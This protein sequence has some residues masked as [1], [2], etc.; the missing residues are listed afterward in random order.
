VPVQASDGAATVV[1]RPEQLVAT[2]VSDSS[3]GQ[4]RDGM[5]TVVGVEFLGH[6]VLL[7]ID[8]PGETDLIVVRQHSLSPPPID[9]K[10]RVQVVGSGVV[11]S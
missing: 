1:L 4:D 10:V 9:A 11:L 6:D 7:T 5:A 3:D 2:V 8:P